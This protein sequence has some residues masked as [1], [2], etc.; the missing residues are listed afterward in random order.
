M[1][2]NSEQGIHVHLWPPASNKNNVLMKYYEYVLLYI[3]KLYYVLYSH[4]G[5]YLLYC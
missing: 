2:T 1:N 5:V 3:M 4:L